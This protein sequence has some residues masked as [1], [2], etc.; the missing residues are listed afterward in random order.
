MTQ[1]PLDVAQKSLRELIEEVKLGVHVLI[2]EKEIP[3]A[4]LS[5]V[6]GPKPKP[7]FG[8]AKGLLRIADDFDAPLDD[9]A[10]YAK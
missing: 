6:A 9:F 1:V 2:T 5:P 4:E 8:S 10:E 3:V 7:V